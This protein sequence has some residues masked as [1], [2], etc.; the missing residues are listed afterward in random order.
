MYLASQPHRSRVGT[1]VGETIAICLN[2][3]LSITFGNR[4]WLPILLIMC[5]FCFEST[6]KTIRISLWFGKFSDSQIRRGWKII[7]LKGFM[8]KTSQ[9]FAPRAFE[10]IKLYRRFGL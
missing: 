3:L 4:G 7:H 8:F 5:W 10:H 9:G 6:I 2:R 1:P